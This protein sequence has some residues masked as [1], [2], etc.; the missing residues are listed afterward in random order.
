[1]QSRTEQSGIKVAVVGVGYWGKNLVRN[2]H[3]LGV[4]AGDDYANPRPRPSRVRF[5]G[6]RRG[7]HREFEANRGNCL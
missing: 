2:F 1:M 5:L 6:E 4:L 3:E 7:V